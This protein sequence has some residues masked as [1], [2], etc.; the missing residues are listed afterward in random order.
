MATGTVGIYIGTE[1]IDVVHLGGTF[2]RP[3]LLNFV[4]TPIPAQ[5]AWRAK[6]RAEESSA[7]GLATAA[8]AGAKQQVLDQE[9]IAELR[10]ALQKANIATNKVYAAASPE[11]I[12]IRYFQM[13]TIP[14]HERKLAVSFEAKK[15]LPFKLEDLITDFQVVVRRAD[16]TIMRIM[17]FGIKKNSMN[18]Y[19]S[20]LQGANIVP[21]CLE[22]APLSVVRL[23]RQTGQL[24]P[25]QVAAIL[26]V[27][28]DT[29]TISIAGET[30]L[31][32]S[33]N[34]SI[35]TTY[36][37]SAT[38]PSGE[39]LEALINETRVSVDYYRRRFLG[40][41]SVSKV[42]LF[43]QGVNAKRIEEMSTTLELPVELGDPFKRITG[44][45]KDIPLTAA[46]AIGLALR[47]LE[48]RQGE[49]N[50]LPAESRREL[51]GVL[52]P[53]GVSL[54]TAAALLAACYFFTMFDLS[55]REQKINTLR[56][57]ETAIKS[58]APGTPLADL[59]T[60]QSRQQAQLR[61]V[62]GIT[63][64]TKDRTTLL[65]EI[66]TLLPPE[67]WVRYLVM[68]DTLTILNNE[69]LNF[70]RKKLL[71]LAGG[72]YAQNQAKEFEGINGFLASLRENRYFQ[73]V[74]TGFNLDAVQRSL[75]EEEEITEFRLT[76]SSNPE[77]AKSDS[78]LTMPGGGWRR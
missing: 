72:S 2:Q 35:M 70:E 23:V 76:C 68:E 22:P 3:R 34:V 8:G 27:E 39:L 54:G 59:Q 25:N 24:Q 42:I 15:Y 58:A 45:M 46:S 61:F 53:V 60:I 30:L 36:D 67:A 19:L 5:S 11:S 49:S 40:E 75:Y 63:E 10:K 74:F 6:I 37:T 13:P 28:K 69:N 7:P 29:A 18:T 33:R 66:T 64:A 57:Q 16:P 78:S 21:L 55:S 31:Y 26:S 9:I 52:K 44:N 17:F 50:L 62:R 77:D 65:A 32:L 56:S 38:E 73:A 41:P 51:S 48:K 43:G 20:L 71:R 47:P 14:P 4:R 12:V 1:N